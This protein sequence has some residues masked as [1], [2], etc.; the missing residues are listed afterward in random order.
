MFHYERQ[1]AL[2]LEITNGGGGRKKPIERIDIRIGQLRHHLL[3][4]PNKKCPRTQDPPITCYRGEY[5]G[6]SLLMRK[7]AEFMK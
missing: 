1:L 5:E 7:A 2:L 3:Q 4:K 6:V